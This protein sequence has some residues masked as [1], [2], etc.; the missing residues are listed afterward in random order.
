MKLEAIRN[1]THVIFSVCDHDYVSVG[2][3][4]QSIMLDGGSILYPNFAGYT[5]YRFAKNWP[6]K[7]LI[8]LPDVKYSD[9]Y[10]DWNQSLKN[11]RKYGI[12]K[13]EDVHI[14]SEKEYNDFI[15]S[16]VW[17]TL[18]WKAQHAIWGTNGINGDQP[19]KYINLIDATGNH[20]TNIL[21]L[22]KSRWERGRISPDKDWNLIEIIEYILQQKK[23]ANQNSFQETLNKM[24]ENDM[25]KGKMRTITHEM[26]M[27]EIQINS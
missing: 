2:E 10:N 18:E 19:T 9:L 13:V 23:D 5:R 22:L 14:Y 17:E 6:K 7:V 27:G 8:E 20:L 4:D 24:I 11:P 26:V 3:D 1:D 15:D 21:L 25:K 16:R 12:H